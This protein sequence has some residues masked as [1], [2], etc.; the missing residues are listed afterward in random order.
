MLI[1]LQTHLQK[2]K[3]FA[4][5]AKAVMTSVGPSNMLWAV[6]APLLDSASHALRAH[7]ASCVWAAKE[8]KKALVW[9]AQ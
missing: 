9:T 7:L 5:V 1:A 2:E 4:Q 3:A 6:V 8:V